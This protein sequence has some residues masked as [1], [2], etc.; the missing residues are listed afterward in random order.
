MRG[1]VILIVVALIVGYMGVTGK[2][3]CFTKMLSCLTNGQADCDCK[4]ASAT[5]TGASDVI[6]GSFPRVAPL[7]PLPPLIRTPPFSG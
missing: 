3:K 6:S 7:Q 4:T 2:Y 5:T 1:G